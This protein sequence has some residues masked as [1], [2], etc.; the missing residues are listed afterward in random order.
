MSGSK[1]SFEHALAR[2]G[3]WYDD[4]EWISTSC[5][6]QVD[7]DHHLQKSGGVWSLCRALGQTQLH[8]VLE[9][10]AP[11]LGILQIGDAFGGDQEQRLWEE[12]SNP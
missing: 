5:F 3:C 11:L 7:G 6:Q 9:V 2:K 12:S 10:G 4:D 1:P 8:E